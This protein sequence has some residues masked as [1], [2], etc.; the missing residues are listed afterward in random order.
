MPNPLEIK[1]IRATVSAPIGSIIEAPYNFGA[2]NPGWLLCDHTQVNKADYP[3]LANQYPSRIGTFTPTIRTPA[4]APGSTAG[5]SNGT[6]WAIAGLN[7][8]TTCIQ[9]TPDGVTWTSRTTPADFDTR[10]ILYMTGNRWV[11]FGSLPGI[12]PLYSSDG[13]VTWN[14][15]TGATSVS[16]QAS[17]SCAAWAPTIGVNGRICLAYGTGSV[18]T[19]DDFGVTFTA[20]ATG[21]SG[22]VNGV[23]WSG[24]MFVA[25]TSSI[26]DIAV[27]TDGITW[28]AVSTPVNMSTTANST[29]A[30]DGL[31]RVALETASVANGAGVMCSQDSGATWSMRLLPSYIGTDN[32]TASH[33]THLVSF[34]NGLF[35]TSTPTAMSVSTDLKTFIPIS[36]LAL[37]GGR[38]NIVSNAGIYMGVVGALPTV[39]TI[40]NNPS[41]MY[42]PGQVVSSG[43]LAYNSLTSHLQWIK[44]R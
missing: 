28:T 34:T 2:N 23:C 4:T 35:F 9:T 17:Q 8:G 11:A 43:S 20:R 33:R 1:P 37:T 44:A 25:N 12:Q 30:S 31:G 27:S 10:S 19:S 36:N 21:V 7:T 42:L 16:A 39:R 24:T 13:A 5:A 18:F 38:A 22:N 3:L 40:T 32:S 15:A 41:K 29:I 6:I 14:L 26:T